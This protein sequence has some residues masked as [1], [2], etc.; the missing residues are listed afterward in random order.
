[1]SCGADYFQGASCVAPHWVVVTDVGEDHVA[2]N[3]LYPPKGGKD[4]FVRREEFQKILDDIGT[5]IGMSPS[6]IF[7]RSCKSVKEPNFQIVSSFREFV[8]ARS[9]NAG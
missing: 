3:D 1:V 9:L 5:R 7:I 4:I 2:F 8:R 6:A